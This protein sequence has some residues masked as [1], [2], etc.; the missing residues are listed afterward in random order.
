MVAL[1]EL[2]SYRNE[3]WKTKSWPISDA[4]LKIFEIG[5]RITSL[6][7]RINTLD[8]QNTITGEWHGCHSKNQL[9][10]EPYL[11]ITEPHISQKLTC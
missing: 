8:K 10:A 1:M 6:P 4:I 5:D 9:S 11:I 3:N 2:Q 7:Q